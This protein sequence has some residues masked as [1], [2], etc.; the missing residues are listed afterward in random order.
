[1]DLIN[2]AY[3]GNGMYRNYFKGVS[4]DAP[5][6]IAKPVEKVEN[7][8]NTTVDTFVKE[9]KDEE[10]KK[11]NK[12]AITVGSTVLVLSALVTL[13]NPKVSGKFIG[14]LKN[15]SQKA[16]VNVQKNKDDF[17]KSKIYKAS[18]KSLKGV[19]DVL[20]Y[21]NTLNASKDIGFKW[22]CS[23]EKFG[24][25]KND[26]L[27]KILQ[28]GNSGFTK[29]M[30]KMNNSITKGFDDIGKK[31]VYRKYN[32]AV[33]NM[34]SVDDLINTYKNRLSDTEKLKL[35]SKMREIEAVKKYFSQEKTAER[36]LAQEKSMSNLEQDFR[37]KFINDYCKKF[38]GFK[39][40]GSF[41]EKMDFNMKHIKNNMSFWAED[42]LMPTRNNLEKQGKDT[43]NMLFGDGKGLKGKYDEIIDIL[44]PHMKGEEKELLEKTLHNAGKKL[45]KA[46]HSECIEY[47]DKK[48]D[49]VLGGA[50]TD[51]LTGL[52]TLGLSGIAIGTA[53]TKEDRISRALTLGFPAVAGLGAS[54]T[55]T[56][57]LF[58]GIQGMIMG[59][60]TGIGLSKI[61]ST[62]DKYLNPKKVN[63][64]KTNIK[65]Q[66]V[67]YA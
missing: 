4:P 15:M 22:L 51:I 66:E 1:M 17:F 52:G 19:V 49:L 58:S 64:M 53:D 23:A 21:I 42:M 16:Q 60:L 35:E 8:I 29:V 47:F 50:P 3:A 11:S 62:A 26:T 18:E 56:A 33:K 31:T 9:P 27:R 61:G 46:N 32:K 28:S 37:N 65:P 5:T 6:I 10:K 25:V 59:S 45:N 12:T 38:K 36:L 24:K 57:M 7:V 63:N 67:T 48:R 41:K 43:V 13:L 44:S 54:L 55:L 30:T 39:A 34:N 2:N 14:K 20:Q 40:E